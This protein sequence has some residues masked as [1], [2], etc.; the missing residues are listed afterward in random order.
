M[1]DNTQEALVT[2]FEE[3][4]SLAKSDPEA[5]ENKRKN[6]INDYIESMPQESRQRLHQLQWRI[7]G[8]RRVAKTPMAAC[9]KIYNMMWE[10]ATGENGMLEH[11]NRLVS[12]QDIKRPI[13]RNASILQFR[14][15]SDD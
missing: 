8:V 2:Q 11:I 13:A 7:D 5:F 9:L 12:E 3:W 1:Q 4:A 6:F 10:S 15:R 14:G